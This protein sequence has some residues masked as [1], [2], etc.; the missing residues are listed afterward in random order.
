VR[1]PA[2]QPEQAR[3]RF[4]KGKELEHSGGEHLSFKTSAD[5]VMQPRAQLQRAAVAER[6]P[7]PTTPQ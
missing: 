6:C 7:P 1:L 4:T 5:T 2:E 3:K